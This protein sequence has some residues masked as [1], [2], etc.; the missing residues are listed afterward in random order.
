MEKTAGGHRRFRPEDIALFRRENLR[1]AS[2]TAAFRLRALPSVGRTLHAQAAAGARDDV[3]LAEAIFE[4]LVAAREEECSA[5]LVNLYLHGRRVAE[6]ADAILR[7]ALRKVGDLWHSGELTV[8]QEHVATRTALASLQA[9]RRAIHPPEENGLAAVCCSVEE[10]FH[11]VPVQFSA[12]TLEAEGWGA[13]VLG[14]STPFYA[15]AEAVERFHPRLVC[16]ASTVLFDL[17]RAARE[18]R[19]VRAAAGRAEAAVVLGGAGFADAGVRRRF[20]AEVYAESF[21]ELEEFA[22]SLSAKLPPV[23]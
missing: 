5:F 19:E 21:R 16:V 6:I 4:G 12:L 23:A 11:E 2:S 13:V 9:L 1:N 7:P 18:Y 8:A 10:D 22:R 20:P 15:L 14:T 17:E 3:E